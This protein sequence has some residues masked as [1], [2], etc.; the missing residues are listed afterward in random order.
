VD[1][2]PARELHRVRH[3]VEAEHLTLVIDA[4]AAGNSPATVWVDDGAAPGAAAIWDGTHSLY[5]AGAAD[6]AGALGASIGQHIASAR[7][8]LVK[9]YATDAAASAAFAGCQLESRERVFYRGGQL[10]IPCWRSRLSAGLRISSIGDEIRRLAAF[11]NFADVSAEIE[12]CWPSIA[13]FRRT[14]FGFCVHDGQVIVCWCTAEYVSDGRCG[15]GI[16]QGYRRQR[17]ASGHLPGCGRLA[18]RRASC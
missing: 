4:M 18:G 5:L 6:R 1:E 14:G 12:S 8:G 17:A 16:A 11:G 2:L 7:P 3:L 13:D 15:I 9:V 10:Q